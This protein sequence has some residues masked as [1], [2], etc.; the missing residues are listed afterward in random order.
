MMR[1]I[2]AV[3]AG[4]TLTLA[5]CVHTGP[6]L[7]TNLAA[8]TDVATKRGDTIDV[9]AP[10]A[11]HVAAPDSR[12][13]HDSARLENSGFLYRASTIHGAYFV[14]PEKIAAMQPR[15]IADIFRHIPVMLEQ[16][17]PSGRQLLAPQGCFF[18]YVNGL[19][20]RT[21]SPSTLDTLIQVGEVVAAEVYPPGQ[22]PPAPFTRSN[23]GAA[24]TTVGIWTRT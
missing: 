14:T 20:R 9:S 23:V 16:P 6:V 1:T 8:V 4:A 24:C 18:T 11:E 12:E 21:S 22:L 15:R 19:P 13:A 5:A 2:N 3:L 17:N 10:G 7:D